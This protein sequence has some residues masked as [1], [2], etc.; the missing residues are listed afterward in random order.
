MTSIIGWK[1]DLAVLASAC[2]PSLLGIAALATAGAHHEISF[3]LG[4]TELLVL[5]VSA[6]LFFVARLLDEAQRLADDHSQ[7]V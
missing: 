4:G 2:A 6:L 3:S 1:L 7:I 5:L